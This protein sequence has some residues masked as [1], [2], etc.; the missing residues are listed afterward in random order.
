M[1]EELKPRCAKC[2]G[3]RQTRGEEAVTLVNGTALCAWHAKEGE[4]DELNRLR[5]EN[6]RLST[7]ACCRGFDAKCHS[8]RLQ[9]RAEAAE[10]KIAAQSGVLE[11]YDK[12]YSEEKAKVSSLEGELRESVAKVAALQ[13]QKDAY[14]KIVSDLEAKVAALESKYG[15]RERVIKNLE[16]KLA[17]MEA[18]VEA[19][20]GRINEYLS[21]GG[22]FNPE[23][24]DHQK[25][26]K[27]MLEMRDALARLTVPEGMKVCPKCSMLSTSNHRFQCKSAP[28]KKPCEKCE[29]TGMV[30]YGNS[31]TNCSSCCPPSPGKGE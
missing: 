24:M 28:E 22:L 26:G 23:M 19:V 25:V 4:K 14:I 13:G 29:G 16:D 11:T 6:D 9:A 5:A 2:Q 15:G 27:M 7:H 31:A 30:V 20:I 18:V 21:L 10:A 3:W 12:I 17:E 8:C 1:R